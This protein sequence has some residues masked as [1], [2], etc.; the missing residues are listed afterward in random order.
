M[1]DLLA[2]YLLDPALVVSATPLSLYTHIHI[3][4]NLS[5]NSINSINSCLYCWWSRMVNRTNH[6]LITELLDGQRD[7]LNWILIR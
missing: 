6:K 7:F 3:T 2:Q 4:V 1:E 5:F